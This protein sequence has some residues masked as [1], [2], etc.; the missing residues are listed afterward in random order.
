MSF[1]NHDCFLIQALSEEGLTSYEIAEK[2]DADEVDVI[3]LINPS[4]F[5]V[6][7]KVFRR[8][9][10]NGIMRISAE[11]DCIEKPCRGCSKWFPLTQEFWHRQ[12]DNLDGALTRCRECE[13]KR[14]QKANQLKA[15]ATHANR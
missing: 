14:R 1:T 6:H 10:R 11:R 5:Y 15:T 8:R 13:L 3:Q 4:V 2:F 7:A 12:R 9:E